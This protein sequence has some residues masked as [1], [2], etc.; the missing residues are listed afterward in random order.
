MR[1][2]VVGLWHLGEVFSGCLAELGNDVVGIDSDPAAVKGLNKAILP[3]D[4]PKLKEI[5]ARNLKNGR[6]EYS[7]DF[8]RLIDCDIAWFTPDIPVDNNDRADLTVLNNLIKMALPYIKNGASIVVSSQLSAGTSKK[9]LDY[10]KS[11]RRDLD[12]D[13]AYVPENLQLGKAVDSFLQPSRVVIGSEDKKIQER[14]SLIFRK[15]KTDIIKVNVASAEMIKHSTNA[16]LSTSLSFIYDIADI[17]EEVGADV[18]EVARGLRADERIGEKA[19]LDA[20]AGFSGGHLAR[21]LQYLSKI[22][23]SAKLDLPVIN[24]VIDKNQNRK[25]IIFKKLTPHLKT[26]NKK[27]IA[28]YGITY[29]SGTPTLASSLPLN[30][31][32]NAFR[33]GS[34]INLCD[35]WVNADEIADEFPKGRYKYSADPY[36]SA[37]G[38]SAII[39]ITPWEELKKLNYEKIAKSMRS[40]K[41]FFDARNYFVNESARMQKA[42]ITYIGVGR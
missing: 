6:L 4:E 19:Y 39:C 42:G 8:E 36:K 7:L 13:Y 11:N 2:A 16:Y 1:I 31:A 26:F 38:S 34:T 22:A 23:D 15:L 3:L 12:F 24:S 30:V 29:K 10:I 32:K 20:S 9:L 37:L 41:I 14:L 40:P 21:D 27:T 18:T 33:K 17:C 28:F 25:K 5:I 35:P